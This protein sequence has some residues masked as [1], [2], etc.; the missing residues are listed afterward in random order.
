MA[1]WNLKYEK[2]FKTPLKDQNYFLKT[3]NDF[4]QLSDEEKKNL[5]KIE[6]KLNIRSYYYY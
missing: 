4:L 2:G 6:Q 3:I 1:K 5:K